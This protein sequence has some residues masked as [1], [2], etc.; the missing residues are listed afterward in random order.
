MKSLLFPFNLNEKRVFICYV[1]I[2]K[3]KK[4]KK[5]YFFFVC[6]LIALQSPQWLLPKKPRPIITKRALQ[7]VI[8]KTS[9]IPKSLSKNKTPNIRKSHPEIPEHLLHIPMF[10]TSIVYKKEKYLRV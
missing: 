8:P 10:Y 5:N 1:Y 9:H 2:K 3:I 6:P 4:I 7:A